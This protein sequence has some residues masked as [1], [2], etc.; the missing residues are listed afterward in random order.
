MPTTETGAVEFL[1]E[2]GLLHKTRQCINGHQMTLYFGHRL[3]WACNT[4]GCRR[5]LG[6]RSGSWFANT[7]LPFVTIVRFIYCWAEEMTSIKWCKKQL[8][9]TEATTVDWNAYMREVA[10]TPINSQ[11]KKMIG[12][13]GEVVEVDE[14][15]FTKRKNHSGRILSS[16][17]PNGY[18]GGGV[19][20]STKECFLVIV[21]WGSRRKRVLP[22]RSN[23]R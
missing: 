21:S 8:G 14:S 19:C 6:I 16:P 3:Q 2:R 17:P 18:L 12:R 23:V 15:L 10:V 9:I 4:L 7:K 5:R 11:E 20:R 22:L 13:I 1:Q